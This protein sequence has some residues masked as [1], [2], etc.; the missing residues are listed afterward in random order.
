MKFYLCSGTSYASDM[1]SFRL[2]LES[3]G[4]TVTSQWHQQPKPRLEIDDPDIPRRARMDLDDIRR[5]DVLIAFAWPGKSQRGG[6][7][8]EA[9]YAWGRKLVW[10]VGKPEHAF[11]T[12][13]DRTF[14][15]W[16]DVLTFVEA[17][18]S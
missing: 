9:G 8:F 12:I 5:A 3:R 10:L 6:R 18:H 1:E 17:R 15:T 2:A 7:H 13:A 16:A 11:H 14:D 4:H